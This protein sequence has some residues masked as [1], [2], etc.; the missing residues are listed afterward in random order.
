VDP[1]PL[2]HISAIFCDIE[3]S[4]ACP[5]G[6]PGTGLV[7]IPKGI[8]LSQA[9]VAFTL[10]DT[11][12]VGLDYSPDAVARCGGNPEVVTYEGAF[13][14][15]YPICVNCIVIGGRY[16]EANA[17]CVALCEDLKGGTAGN[18]SPELVAY[19]ESHS[20]VSTNA[21]LNDCAIGACTPGGNLRTDFADPRRLPEPVSWQDLTGVT[22]SFTIEPFGV[23][24]SSLTRTLATSPPAANPPFDAGAASTQLFTHGDGYLEFAA[25]E[26][27][28]SHVCGLSSI[29]SECTAQPQPAQC[30][31][32][33]ASLG[34]IGFSISLNKD[35]RF[36]V[37]ENGLLI[38]GLDVNGSF[39]TY[40]PAERFRVT[41][42]DNN[43][44]ART[45]TIAYSRVLAS[46]GGAACP[47]NVFY[48]HSAGSPAYPLRVDSSFR[49]QGAT[50]TGVRVVRIK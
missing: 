34:D 18:N 9:A 39:G 11:S 12:N 50:L 27:T 30:A 38:A 25:V 3:K 21:P 29:A 2:N 43:D 33:D 36:Y 42:K 46:C 24:I 23:G 37:I 28:L 49:E 5:S 26:N 32:G 40:G 31:D 8:P 48:T 17:V 14:E 1:G 19:C 35:G 16:P 20:K 13:P 4:R 10:G 44:I 7:L 15:G 45:A 41:V 22:A 47:D 6:D